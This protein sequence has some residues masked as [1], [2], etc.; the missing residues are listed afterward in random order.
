MT[1]W[2]RVH[3][4]RPSLHTRPSEY[5]DSI[6]TG[7]YPG[8]K[9]GQHLVAEQQTSS[10]SIRVILRRRSDGIRVISADGIHRMV[11]PRWS[12]NIIREIRAIRGRLPHA[13]DNLH[14]RGYLKKRGQFFIQKNH[15]PKHLSPSLFYK[16]CKCA[17]SR[18]KAESTVWIVLLFVSNNG[19]K[20]DFS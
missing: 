12:T 16:N 1:G 4:L 18:I 7:M 9:T 8:N 11:Q 20:I 3:G 14:R 5:I 13:L 10:A 19:N 2:L 15:A 6:G 17:S